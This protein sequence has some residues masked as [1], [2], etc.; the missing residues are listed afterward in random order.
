MDRTKIIT[1]GRK[2]GSCG[3]EI[4]RLVSQKLGIGFY[5]KEI[6]TEAAKRS[7]LCDKFVESIDE[8][9][10]GS[11]LY[12]LVMNA[13]HSGFA[14]EKPIELIAYE[15][16]LEALREAAK[17]GPCVIVGRAADYILRDNYDILSVFF[18][19]PLP[20]RLKVIM[21]RYEINEKEA[22]AKIN[23]LDK[24][25][26]SYYNYHTE[27]KWGSADSFDICLNTSCISHEKA[28]DIIIE[29]YHAK[30]F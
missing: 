18:T 10:T 27:S 19:A 20:Y 16:Q 28:A 14:A 6:I 22:L 4:G 1:V 3:R 24:A 11:L 23:R 13:Q 29:Y 25:R 30:Q 7:G 17:H 21:E 26:S 15:A 12:S 5:D 8:R 2:F 9:P